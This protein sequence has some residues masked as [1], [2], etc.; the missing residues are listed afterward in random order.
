ML[1]LRRPC[2]RHAPLQRGGRSG[3]RGPG[4]L[5][6]NL[7][8][9]RRR[10]LGQSARAATLALL[11]VMLAGS[12]AFAAGDW[13]QL[14]DEPVALAWSAAEVER[15]TS[16]T[17]RAQVEQAAQHG[18]LGCRTEC[19]RYDRIF[20]RLVGVARRQTE[21]ARRLPWSLTVL[22]SPD[23]DALA[24]PGG[25]VMIS[26]ASAP[27]RALPDEALA[28]VLAH[29][30]AH[31]ILEHERQ[32]LHFARQLLPRDVVRSVS[33]VYIEIDHSFELLKA[34]EPIMQQ[35]EF[36]AD[37]LGLWLASAAGFEPR[38]QLRFIEAEAGRDRGRAVLVRTHPPA[39][40]RLQRLRQGLPL[41]DRLF[42]LSRASTLRSIEG[43]ASG[44]A[45][46]AP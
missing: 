18:L 6:P 35:G 25:Q 9:I 45:T 4:R 46:G 31:S 27:L 14:A 37:E 20:Q 39:R 29:E 11:W 10:W 26:E 12:K 16:G 42:A 22:R 28:F 8:S 3:A 33:D 21:R 44:P 43:G 36:E 38:Q 1:C 34:L 23:V 2:G 19:E 13:A 32:T 30:M 40:A 41:A 7:F 15:A 17:L 5:G 24:L